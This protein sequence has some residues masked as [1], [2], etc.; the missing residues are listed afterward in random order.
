MFLFHLLFEDFQDP[1]RRVLVPFGSFLSASI[2]IL[3]VCPFTCTAT[4]ENL[5]NQIDGAV[6]GLVCN[7][8]QTV[9][10]VAGNAANA[11]GGSE[12]Q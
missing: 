1:P 4:V 11:A 12:F 7:A 10:G 5:I 8:T 6:G 9:T 3:T 2:S